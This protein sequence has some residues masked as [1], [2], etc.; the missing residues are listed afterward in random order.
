MDE[1]FNAAAWLVDRHVAE[2]RGER[3][4]YRC[5]DESLTYRGLQKLVWTT[6]NGLRSLN[7]EPGDRVLMVV[8][9]HLAFPATFLAGLLIGAVPV[10]VST[11]LKAS[12]VAVLL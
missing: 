5:G 11:M 10:P 12:E 8:S 9:D 1:P 3:V 2:G 7:V 6:A 4:A